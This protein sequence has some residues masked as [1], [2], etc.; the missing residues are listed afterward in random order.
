[1]LAQTETYNWKGFNLLPEVE[2]AD[3][4]MRARG[5]LDVAIPTFA[6]IF[7]RYG[8]CDAWGIGLL[9]RHW[10]LVEGER[11]VQEMKAIKDGVEFVTRPRGSDFAHPL[12]PSILRVATGDRP[13]LHALELSTDSDVH[14]ANRLLNATPAFADAFCHA[15]IVSGLADTF[16]LIANKRLPDASAELVEYNYANRTSVLREGSGEED[17]GPVIQTSWRFV[18]DHDGIDCHFRCT[19]KCTPSGDGHTSG[20]NYNHGVDT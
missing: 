19:A 14:A 20:H 2:L 9:H 3:A 16:A 13:S 6:P 12:A 11:P 8:F 5:L 18:P 17:G 10:L 15:A 4:D 7:R 1:M